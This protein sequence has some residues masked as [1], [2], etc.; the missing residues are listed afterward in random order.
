[1][2]MDLQTDDN[3]LSDD[4]LSLPISEGTLLQCHSDGGAR[5]A[6]HSAGAYTLALLG[7]DALGMLVSRSCMLKAFI[8]VTRFLRLDPKF[9]PFVHRFLLSSSCAR[10]LIS[11]L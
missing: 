7:K 5:G 11:F 3:F 10:I 2:A 6:D 9:L 8:W 1:M 4:L